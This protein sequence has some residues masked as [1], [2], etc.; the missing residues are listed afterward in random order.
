MNRTASVPNL[1]EC[2]YFLN[3]IYFYLTEGCN[4]RCRHCWLAPKYESAAPRYP[5]LPVDRFKD[6]V[7]QG[8]ELG[9]SNVK[10]TGGEPLLHPDIEQI[11]DHVVQEK[12]GLTVETN[13][14]RCTPDLARS[15]A[16]CANSF[17][18]IS[19][20]GADAATHEWVRGV[21]GC[22]D[23]AL[24][25]ARNLLAAGIQPQFIMSIMKHNVHQM[26]A[27]VRLAEAM[28]MESV[29]FNLVTPTAR[30]EQMHD[31]GETLPIEELVRLGAW[32]ENELIP[33]SRVRVVYSH[34]KAFK[35][36]RQVFAGPGDQCGIF[37]IIGVLANG[38]Y[39]LCGIGETVPDLVFGH[40]DT[41]QLADIWNHNP[42]LG[43]IRE[44]LPQRLTGICG[45]CLLNKVCIGNCIAMNYYRHHD[46]FA[47][48]WYCEEA[49]RI[50]AF[51][52]SRIRP[53]KE[54]HEE[55]A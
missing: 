54:C 38:K 36:L 39:A 44:G 13:G 33:N 27:V 26:E 29:K 34:P 37:G 6:I 48:F 53:K 12:L 49:H 19:L 11:L 5:T 4:L 23:D 25:G 15:M 55:L 41:D 16:R 9:M 47:P 22:F 50:G 21:T 17:V 20:D 51:P 7:A 28:G 46:L 8:R 2:G 35:S 52:A 18:S 3:T 24:A 32:V 43:Q 40:V 42:I 30:G 10:L 31:R 45:E 1:P 14:V